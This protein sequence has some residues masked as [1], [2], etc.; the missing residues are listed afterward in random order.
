MAIDTSQIDEVMR[1]EQ[2]EHERKMQR[3]ADV[4]RMISDPETIDLVRSI[5]GSLNTPPGTAPKPEPIATDESQIGAIRKIIA[6]HDGTFSV[7]FIGDKL[8]AG[9]MDIDNI[10]V[11]R[12]L[13]RLCKKYEE[14]EIAEKSPGGSAPNTYIKTERLK[15]E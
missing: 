14:I 7:G 4:K 11:G 3:F 10:A 9:R 5:L 6:S 2:E 12:V 15:S 8:R 13:Q 1:R